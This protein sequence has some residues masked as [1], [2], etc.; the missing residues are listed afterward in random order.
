MDIPTHSAIQYKFRKYAAIAKLLSQPLNKL[1]E[2]Y[3]IKLYIKFICNLV[4]YYNQQKSQQ[5]GILS[6]AIRL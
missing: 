4:K 2:E 5:N 6:K 1:E 3:T